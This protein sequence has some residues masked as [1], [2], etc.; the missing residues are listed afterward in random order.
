MHPQSLAQVPERTEDESGPVPT[1]PPGERAEVKVGRV[2]TGGGAPPRAPALRAP[3]LA[4]ARNGGAGNGNRTRI[5]GLEGRSSTIELSPLSY[6][7][8]HAWWAGKDS[9]LRRH[10]AS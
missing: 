6:L 1:E 4:P 7:R 8:R 3:P 2:R 10:S 9:N 5:T